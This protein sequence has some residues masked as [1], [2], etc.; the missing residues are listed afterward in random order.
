MQKLITTILLLITFVTANA[1]ARWDDDIVGLIKQ[2]HQYSDHTSKRID[3]LTKHFVNQA[4][5]YVGEPLGEG[6]LGRFSQR[7]LYRLDVFDCTTFV[8]TILAMALTPAGSDSD[9]LAIF[10]QHMNN[11]RYKNGEVDFHARN[12]FPSADWVPN[13]IAAGYV[14]DVSQKVA[15]QWGKTETLPALID[16]KAWYGYLNLDRICLAGDDASQYPN[17]SASGE[18][19]A[20][21]LALLQLEGASQAQNVV[22][23]IP[24]LPLWELFGKFS[25][26]KGQLDELPNG[27]I[28][29]IVRPR[30]DLREW[31]G[32]RMHVSHQGIVIQQPGKPAMLR[33]ASTTAKQVVEEP[34]EDY[35][36][37]YWRSEKCNQPW[38]EGARN[39][40]RGVNVLV[41][42]PKA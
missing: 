1:D 19:H 18:Q 32:T 41:P 4:N 38:D 22:A 29:Q 14:E 26:M 8:E 11:I 23:T 24:Y 6:E 5:P 35:L 15:L 30:Y 16:K 27:S 31:I 3:F 36:Y 39:C 20:N 12:H 2:S 10:Q 7:P 28:I 17:C 9:M 13:N 25:D 34:L 33:H 37:K 21:Q 40:I 42:A